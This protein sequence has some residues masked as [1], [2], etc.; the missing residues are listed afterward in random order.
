M[1]IV[2]IDKPLKSVWHDWLLNYYYQWYLTKNYS[3]IIVDPHLSDW[4]P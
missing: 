1:M 2:A 4:M 3:T